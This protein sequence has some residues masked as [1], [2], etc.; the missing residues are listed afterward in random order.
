MQST[1]AQH[2]VGAPIQIK[3]AALSWS[4]PSTPHHHRQHQGKPQSLHPRFATPGP[5]HSAPGTPRTCTSDPGPPA[6]SRRPWVAWSLGPGLQRTSARERRRRNGY[7]GTKPL[8]VFR[9][10]APARCTAATV[11]WS[12]KSQIHLLCVY[13]TQRQHPEAS[14]RNTALIKA[15]QEHLSVLGRVPWVVGATGT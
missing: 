10:P 4:E 14:A 9:Q 13:G 11:L 3:G 6:P 12:R 7:I 8:A 1:L 15:I 2:R 5:G